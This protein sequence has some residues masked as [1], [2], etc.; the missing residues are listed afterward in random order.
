MRNRNAKPT[1]NSY[2]AVAPY[3][4]LLAR[5]VFGRSIKDAQ[6]AYLNLISPD[7]TVLILGGGTGW[8]LAELVKRNP[9]LRVCYVDTSAKMIKLSQ[10]RLKGHGNVEFIHGDITTIPQNRLFDVAIANFFFDQFDEEGIH[11]LLMAL[12]QKLSTTG[13]LLAADFQK[14]A[15]WHKIMLKIM[16]AFF[17]AAGAISYQELPDWYSVL[18]KNGFN[19]VRES[20]HY[21]GFIRTVVFAKAKI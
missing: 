2:D 20:T 21:L 16:Y 17:A 12:H 9:G 14:N 6:T 19:P 5:I 10:T 11:H 1:L 3:Y 13:I 8:L 4:D 7:A 15:L 18:K